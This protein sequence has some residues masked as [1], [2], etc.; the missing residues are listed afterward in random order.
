MH[1]E[2]LSNLFHAI[3]ATLI[4]EEKYW[5]SAIHTYDIAPVLCPCFSIGMQYSIKPLTHI[6]QDLYKNIPILV[7]DVYVFKA[8][9]T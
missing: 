2:I 6:R 4:G 1:S 8:I 5:G 7:N 9:T 3:T